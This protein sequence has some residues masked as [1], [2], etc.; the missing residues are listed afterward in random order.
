MLQCATFAQLSRSCATAQL[1]PHRAQLSRNFDS[2]WNFA[3][4]AWTADKKSN[5]VLIIVHLAEIFAAKWYN[6]FNSSFTSGFSDLQIWRN[7]WIF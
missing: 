2:V 7:F 5:L 4:C 6:I 3:V 1:L